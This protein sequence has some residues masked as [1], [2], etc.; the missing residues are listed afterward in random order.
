MNF[1]SICS[2]PKMQFRKLAK[3][4]LL[5]EA[6]RWFYSESQEQLIFHGVLLSLEKATPARTFAQTKQTLLTAFKPSMN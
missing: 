1:R 6:T 5:I 3:W 4:L 2:N